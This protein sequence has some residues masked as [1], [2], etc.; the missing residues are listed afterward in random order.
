MSSAWE[1]MTGA[2]GSVGRW[3]AQRGRNAPMAPLRAKKV[4]KKATRRQRALRLKTVDELL[5]EQR[6]AT[7]GN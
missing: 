4:S 7:R 2:T 3:T 1:W 5:E 6:N